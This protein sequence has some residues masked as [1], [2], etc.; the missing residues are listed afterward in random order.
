MTLAAKR[1]LAFW[2]F[3]IGIVG[4]I[5]SFKYYH[6]DERLGEMYTEQFGDKLD[7]TLKNKVADP[8]ATVC[9][10]QHVLSKVV[11][12]NSCADG[13]SSSD[14]PF[15]ATF[16]IDT[17]DGTRTYRGLVRG[18]DGVYTEYTWDPGNLTTAIFKAPDPTPVACVDPKQVR[19]NWQGIITCTDMH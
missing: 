12:S 14:K 3:G 13:A 4:L 9:P 8:D 2:L 10:R 16:E 6:A 17:G 7:R 19:H 18:K 15:Y 1:K 5:F 11:I